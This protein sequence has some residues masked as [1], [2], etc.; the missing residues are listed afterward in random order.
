MVEEFE[1]EG[2]NL[3]K[4]NKE[5]KSFELVPLPRAYTTSQRNSIK[6]VADLAYGF[7][8]HEAKSLI[9]H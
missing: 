1:Q 5:T 6:E 7:Y 2:Y 4:W 3:K 9:D 8:D